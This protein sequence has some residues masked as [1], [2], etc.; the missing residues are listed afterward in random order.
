[1]LGAEGKEDEEEHRGSDSL[2]KCRQMDNLCGY[3]AVV[4]G[5]AVGEGVKWCYSST[6][7]R[8]RKR[9]RPQCATRSGLEWDPAERH[10]KRST[11]SRLG[12]DN[13]QRRW[14]RQTCQ[15]GFKQLRR[16]KCGSANSLNEAQSESWALCRARRLNK[17]KKMGKKRCYQTVFPLHLAW[18]GLMYTH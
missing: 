17:R 9:L 6:W 15:A 5:G 4:V 1:M 7:K 10:L 8:G 2:N 11:C 16:T 13:S 12:G 3:V 18:Q 14:T